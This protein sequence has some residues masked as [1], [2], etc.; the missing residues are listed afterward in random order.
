[1]SDRT[2]AYRFE[3]DVDPLLSCAREGCD[4]EAH[5]REIMEGDAWQVS[6]DPSV[7]L[8]CPLCLKT[9]RRRRENHQLPGTG[10]GTRTGGRS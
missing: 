10:T 5:W 8:L 3:P 4:S 6:V 1:M 9:R 2:K 7:D